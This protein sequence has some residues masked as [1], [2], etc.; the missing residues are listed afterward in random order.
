M[1]S[2]VRCCLEFQDL[3]KGDIGVVVNADPS[4]FNVKV[5]WKRIG[6]SYWMRYKYIEFLNPH[7]QMDSSA[8]GGQCCLELGD[9]VRVKSTVSTPFYKWGN[10]THDSVGIIRGFKSEGQ[11]V[12]VDFLTQ[13]G[14]KGLTSEMERVPGSPNINMICG[15]CQTL[16][17]KGFWYKCR[18]CPNFSFCSK[19]YKSDRV[20]MHEL[21]AVKE[22]DMCVS[23]PV[24]GFI[25]DWRRCVKNVTVSSRENW[26]YR[27]TDGSK[28]FWQSSGKQGK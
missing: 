13:M 17:L 14:W 10:V 22:T 1:G 7:L 12:I 2:L 11:K 15:G 20:H 6:K 8:P 25:E 18:T 4:S 28:Y 23:K 5:E 26:A 16:L 9:Q 21:Y 19:C 3:K 24:S 27:L